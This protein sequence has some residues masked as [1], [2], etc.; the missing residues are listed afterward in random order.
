MAIVKGAGVAIGTN[1]LGYLREAIV[2]GAREAIGTNMLGYLREAVV[3]GASLMFK[4][5]Y[6]NAV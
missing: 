6:S 5:I 4:I 1:M 3:N 2:N